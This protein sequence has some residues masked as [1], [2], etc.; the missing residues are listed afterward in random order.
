VTPVIATAGPSAYWYLS[1]GTGAVTLLLLTISLVLGIV[2]QRRWRAPGWPRFVLDALHRN[3]SLLVLAVLTVHILTSVLDSF[4]PIKLTDAV[5]PFTSAYRPI[6]VGLGALTFDCLLAIA[7]T[8]L[9]RQRLGHRAW[10]LVHWLAYVAWPVAVVHGL[11]TG[12]DAQQGWMLALTAICIT[13]VLA[14]VWTR[15]IAASP[16]ATAQRTAALAA[17]IIGPVALVAWLPHGPLGSGWA[18]R[19]G[20]PTS[21]LASGARARTVAGRSPKQMFAVPFSGRLAGRFRES[22][23]PG[24]L[25]TVDLKMRF[26]AESNGV[27]DVR[28]EG[29]PLPGGG[30]RMMQSEV[31]LGPSSRPTSYRGHVLALQGNRLLATASDSAGRRLRVGMVLSLDSAARSVAGTISARP[32]SAAAG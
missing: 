20:T 14:A 9:L 4:A 25:T 24:T 12:S 16:E 32:D 6:W 26:R 29:E 10:R 8:S 18:R 19:A 23:G 3:V 11:G 17:I 28:L 7:L 13:A 21:L 30:V 5:V 15:V 31:T 22:P 1:R 2:D 27:A